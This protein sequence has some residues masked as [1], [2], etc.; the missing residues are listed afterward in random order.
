MDS[1]LHINC[2]LMNNESTVPQYSSDE[3]Q[4]EPEEYTSHTAPPAESAVQSDH[5]SPVNSS[6]CGQFTSVSVDGGSAQSSVLSDPSRRRAQNRAAQ[7]AFRERREKRVRVLEEQVADITPKYNNMLRDHEILLQDHAKL[8][9][10]LKLLTKYAAEK[11]SGSVLCRLVD[12][13]VDKVE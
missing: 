10:I 11:D 7:R 6:Q 4:H 8:Q 2:W 13:A 9:E 1:N 3:S 12:L 5:K